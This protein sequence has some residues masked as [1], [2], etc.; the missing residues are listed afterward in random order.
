LLNGLT[1]Q[2]PNAW[3]SSHASYTDHTIQTSH[4]PTGANH[5]RRN[6]A[7]A[8]GLYHETDGISLFG[9]RRGLC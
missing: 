5:P 2:Q 1:A 9:L 7:L 8:T 4:T 3:A 6:R